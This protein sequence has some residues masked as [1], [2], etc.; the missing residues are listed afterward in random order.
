MGLG[1]PE[2]SDLIQRGP[3]TAKGGCERQRA[4]LVITAQRGKVK[5]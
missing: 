5:A 3:A 2:Q 1:S 4:L